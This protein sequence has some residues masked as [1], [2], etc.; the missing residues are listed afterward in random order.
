MVTTNYTLIVRLGSK[1]E[2]PGTGQSYKGASEI[3]DMKY[4]VVYNVRLP[5]EV[6]SSNYQSHIKQIYPTRS[7]LKKNR[8][9]KPRS[10]IVAHIST[11]ENVPQ[12]QG[13]VAAF[14]F[15]DGRH[16]LTN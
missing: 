8:L 3:G 12:L 14:P 9:S 6:Y 1:L 4:L 2:E 11:Q 13:K 16:F 5:A 15:R 10:A 7:A